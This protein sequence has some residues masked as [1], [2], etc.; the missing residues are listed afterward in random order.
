M[1]YKGL[2]SGICRLSATHRKQG[3]HWVFG[4]VPEMNRQAVLEAILCL[5]VL[6]FRGLRPFSGPSGSF[7]GVSLPVGPGW[8]NS[9]T[10]QPQTQT[11]RDTRKGCLHNYMVMR[12]PIRS[13]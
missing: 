12:C 11:N 2:S 6:V 13:A 3:A 8:G 1:E 4:W 5:T 10:V 7:G 9:K